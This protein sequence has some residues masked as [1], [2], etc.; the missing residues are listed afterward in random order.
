MREQD[1]TKTQLIDELA[2]LRQR[3]FELEESEKRHK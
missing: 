1:K 3:V 2:D